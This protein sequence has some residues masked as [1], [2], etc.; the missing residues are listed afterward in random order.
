MKLDKLYKKYIETQCVNCK[1]K[2]TDLCEIRITQIDKTI[3]TKCVYYEKDKDLSK[4]KRI[5]WRTARQNKPLMK[6]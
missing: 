1:N 3:Y 6:L 5:L 4:P 2:K